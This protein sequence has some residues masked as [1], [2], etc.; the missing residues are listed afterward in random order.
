[1]IDHGKIGE[2]RNVVNSLVTAHATQLTNVMDGLHRMNAEPDLARETLAYHV[3]PFIDLSADYAAHW[4]DELAPKSSFKARPDHNVEPVRIDKTIRWALFAPGE[5]RSP[6]QRLTASAQRMIYDGAR[7]TVIANAESEGVPWFRHA[8]PDACR[9]CRVLTVNPD[10][11]EAPHTKMPTHDDDC[12]CLAVPARPGQ[13]YSHP[14]YVREWAAEYRA[15]NTGDLR[16][17]IRRMS[18]NSV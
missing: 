1:M 12:Q 16:S 10:A 8:P 11:Y 2:L 5:S 17:T 9:L 4:Y 15:A 7:H 18:R 13:K 14:G 6:E 3:M